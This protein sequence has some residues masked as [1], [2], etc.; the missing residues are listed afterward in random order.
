VPSPQNASPA[1]TSVTT[2]E[3]VVE[4]CPATPLLAAPQ[5]TVDPVSVPKSAKR[6]GTNGD[7]QVENHVDFEIFKIRREGVWYSLVK[8]QDLSQTL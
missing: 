7:F 8:K 4:P 2:P 5:Q 1:V 6:T 3:D